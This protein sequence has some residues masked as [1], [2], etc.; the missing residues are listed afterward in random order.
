MAGAGF[1]YEYHHTGTG[2]RGTTRETY[3]IDSDVNP[4]PEQVAKMKAWDHAAKMAKSGVGAVTH[5]GCVVRFIRWGGRYGKRWTPEERIFRDQIVTI[6]TDGA[7]VID[8]IRGDAR[9]LSGLVVAAQGRVVAESHVNNQY[10][11]AHEIAERIC[12]A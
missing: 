2:R 11:T 5:S 1:N 12:H 6:R 4:T 7:V 9:K 8:G 3:Y 10:G